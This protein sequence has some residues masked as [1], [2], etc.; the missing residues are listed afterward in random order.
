MRVESGH[1]TKIACWFASLE[2][3]IYWLLL[4]DW[5]GHAAGEVASRMAL[6]ELEEFFKAHPL[7]SPQEILKGAIAKANKE[8]YRLAAENPEYHGMGTTLVTAVIVGGKVLIAGVGDSRAYL[9][10]DAIKQI[11][12]DH[13]LVQDM[14]EKGDIKKAE[15]W[16]HPQ[17]N[18]VTQALGMADE[19]QPDFFEVD[20]GDRFL[21]LCSDGLTDALRDQKIKDVIVSSPDLEAACTRLIDSANDLGGRD[22]TSVILARI[23]KDE[24]KAS[25]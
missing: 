13:S 21:L 22:N 25:N 23:N 6:I 11:T 5:G 18:I 17:K 14:V 12:R 2:T 1:L 16:D 8:I 10:T 20:L 4:T 3:Y 19:V 15:A 24:I 9:I 7:E